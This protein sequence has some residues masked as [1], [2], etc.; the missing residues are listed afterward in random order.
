MRVDC[1]STVC[2]D[3]PR[4]FLRL[5]IKTKQDLLDHEH[6]SRQVDQLAGHLISLERTDRGVMITITRG[7]RC[8]QH[9]HVDSCASFRLPM[10]ELYSSSFQDR[11]SCCSPRCET[12]ESLSISK[13]SL[14]KS[15]LI[16]TARHGRDIPWKMALAAAESARRSSVQL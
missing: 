7:Y 15:G 13:A 10:T 12:L 16:M 8:P 6:M 2:L 11:T 3:E 14:H 1:S 5:M 4:H 9:H